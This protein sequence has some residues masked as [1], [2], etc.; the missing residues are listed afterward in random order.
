[1]IRY[2]LDDAD[3]DI[4]R[5]RHRDVQGAIAVIAN[6]MMGVKE[7]EPQAI[8]KAEGGVVVNGCEICIKWDFLCDDWKRTGLN[9]PTP[10]EKATV[11]AIAVVAEICRTNINALDS[12]KKLGPFGNNLSSMFQRF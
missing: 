1:M 7:V 3:R 10:E 8:G 9:A 6:K 2:T 4:M 11:A 12:Y 5:T